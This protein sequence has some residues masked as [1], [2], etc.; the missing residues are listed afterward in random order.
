[1]RRLGQWPWP[2]T[3]LAEIV[4]RLKSAG[5]ASIAFDVMFAEPDRMSLEELVKSMS[6]STLRTR[7]QEAA[8]GAPTNDQVFAA[9]VA[10]APVVLGVI[11]TPRGEASEVPQR[12][13]VAVAGDDPVPFLTSF[14][15]VIRPV[16]DLVASAAGFGAL[17]WAPRRDQIVRQAPVMMALAGKMQP[18]LAAEALRVAQGASTFVVRMHNASGEVSFGA[19][20][21]VNSVRIG[22]VEVATSG[23]SEVRVRYSTTQPGRFIP[24][25]RLLAGEVPDDQIDGRIILIGTS[26]AGL[27]DLRATPVD[28]VAPGVEVHAQ[29]LENIILGEKLVRPDWAPGA[30][31][32]LALIFAAAMA[33]ALPRL[34]PVAAALFGAA[35]AL[36]IGA[37]SWFAFRQ[38]GVLLDPVPALGLPAVAY[39]SGTVTMLWEAQ[40]QRRQVREAFGRFVSPDVVAQIAEAPDKLVLGGETRELTLMFCDLRDFT[41]MSE[42]LDAQGV[43]RFMNDYLTP[44]TDEVLAHRGTV[45]KYMGDAIMAFWNAPLDNPRHA[46]DACDA[47]LAMIEALK[48]FNAARAA[49]MDPARFKPARFGIGIATGDCSVGNLGS[50]RRFDYSAIG[51]PVNLA[52]RIEGITKFYGMQLLLADNTL[53]LAGSY[54]ALLVDEVRVKGRTGVTQLYTLLGGPDVAASEGFA[55][56][57]G[58][59]EAWL[60]AYRAGDLD[61]AR[62]AA[63]AILPLTAGREESWPTYFEVMLDR[64][65]EHQAEDGAPPWSPVRNMTTK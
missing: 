17:N 26:A 32:T 6:E 37:G 25:W 48:A 59:H 57:R 34:K 23:D 11:L 46:A 38:A 40:N 43:T 55:G 13:G 50:V 49:K 19:G 56:W 45:D 61:A 58:L 8:V 64:L 52:S 18:T 41:S 35:F 20:T 7:V 16:S 65:A 51:D 2:R 33:L 60:A 63:K 47:A 21:G 4:E 10:N 28:A 24:A 14:P 54:A 53:Q 42:G 31:L 44:L 3:R 1:M 5:A 15:R 36:L 62:A 30:E 29:L 9:A 12:F 27:V 22:A 39:L